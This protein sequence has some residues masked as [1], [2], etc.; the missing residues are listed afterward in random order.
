MK[1][2][3]VRPGPPEETIGLKSLMVV[4]PLELE[5][6]A[7]SVSADNEV[8]IADLL[9]E[10]RS[11]AAIV[12]TFQPDVVGVTGYIVNVYSMMDCCR[13][14]KEIK[15]SVVTVAG[16]VH[17]EL[18]PGDLDS[19]FVDYRVVFNATRNFPA[20][21]AFI[22]GK[23]ALPDGV[24]TR[25]IKEY[26]RHG[27]VPDFYYPLPRREL[28]AAFRKKYYYVFHNKVTLVKTSFGCPYSCNFC[29]CR[30]LTGGKYAVRQLEE[31]VDEIAGIKGREIYVADD[32][33]L[34]SKER[35]LQF[36]RLVKERGIRKRYLIYGRSD[37][38][39][40]HPDVMQ[41]FKEIGLRTV[42]VGIESFNDSEL[43]V[44]NKQVNAAVNEE[45][46]R[47]LN[48]YRIDCYAAVVT[49]DTYTDADF[50]FLGD[51]LNSLGIK[52]V[53][54]QPVTPLKGTEYGAVTRDLLIAPDDFARWDLAHVVIKPVN[55]S[56]AD[57]YRNIIRLYRRILYKP[58]NILSNF[59]YS[60]LFVWKIIRGSF[61]VWSQYRQKVKEAERLYG[62]KAGNHL[63]DSLHA[64]RA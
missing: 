12:R 36:I 42:I 33:F 44:L 14:A 22:K 19:E 26:N 9:L 27:V 47:V 5:V 48:R 32:N 59:K 10:K 6:L 7:A 2:L 39:A 38:I 63:Q 31:V 62:R 23:G 4:E 21:L 17:V 20:L 13:T 37:F 53:N 51:K 29:Y 16:G 34:V 28:T 46:V 56:V 49:L 30:E 35:V 50:R 11:L 54:I 43:S 61:R 1:I 15:P 60:P 3:L 24:L 57:Y 58:R 25:G 41:A 55:M 8:R 64:D 40:A 45:A 52:Y 18:N